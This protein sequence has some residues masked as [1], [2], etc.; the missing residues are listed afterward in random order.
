MTADWKKLPGQVRHVFTHFELTLAVWA[1]RVPGKGDP[2]LGVWVE[3]DRFGDFA[4]PSLMMK[5]VR[6]VLG[7]AR[8]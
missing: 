5:V 1:G 7:K 8:S 6:H 3:P 2:K 4:L